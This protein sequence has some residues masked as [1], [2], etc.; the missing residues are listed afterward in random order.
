MK[1]YKK[2]IYTQVEYA[3]LINKT[4]ARVNQMIKNNELPNNTRILRIQGATLIEIKE[5]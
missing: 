3:K 1:I 5:A 4:P 2:N